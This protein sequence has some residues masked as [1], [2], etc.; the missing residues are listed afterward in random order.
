MAKLVIV[1]SGGDLLPE[2]YLNPLKTAKETKDPEVLL[3][4]VRHSDN[5]EASQL[6]KRRLEKEF[7]EDYKKLKQA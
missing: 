1:L 5:M 4:I 6:A 2:V 7:P 3:N